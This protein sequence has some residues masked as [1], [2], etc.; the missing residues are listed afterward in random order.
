M[1]GGQTLIPTLKQRPGAAHRYHRSDGLKNTGITV[2][3]STLAIKAGTAH[4]E[5][6][7]KP[8]R[9]E[10]AIPALAALAGWHRRSACAPQGN[11]RRLDRQQRSGGRLS[12]GAG[13]R[14]TPRSSPMRARSPADKFFTGMFETALKATR[15]S[16]RWSSPFRKTRRLC[17]S[18]RNPASRYA[19]VG[20]FVAEHGG[21][22]VRVAV[23]GAGPGV[24][25]QRR[26]GSGAGQESFTPDAVRGI[27]TNPA[28]LN[29]DIH[30]SAEYRA[31]LVR[32]MARR[33]VQAAL[34]G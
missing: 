19:M 31:H 6:A 2:S 12:G 30:A 27:A 25:R 14:S 22:N 16:R 33:A 4:A 18:S 29:S 32:V 5:V 23:T 1:S 34:S 15:S 9:E 21:G 10:G 17:R 11:D 7:G 8:R 13:R 28:N 20:V 24:F 3:G 26:H